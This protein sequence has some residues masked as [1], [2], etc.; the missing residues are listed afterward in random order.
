MV[1][2]MASGNTIP[3]VDC[4]DI[5]MLYSVVDVA[6]LN[7]VLKQILTN[8][9]AAMAGMIESNRPPEPSRSKRPT[10][11]MT[12]FGVTTACVTAVRE[13]L[14]YKGY[15]CLVFHATGTGGRAMEKLVESGY[16]DGVLDITTTEVADEIVGGIM[17]AGSQRIRTIVAKQIPYVVSVGAVDMVNFGA[18]KTVPPQFANRQ[19]H[20][21]NEHVTLMRTTTDENSRIGAWIVE[22]LNESKSPITVVLPVGGVSALDADDEIF[23]NPSANA[24]LFKQFENH[25]NTTEQR[26]LVESAYHVNDPEFADLLV[27]EF[28]GLLPVQI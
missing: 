14:E 12:M 10:V 28:C 20:G 17:P 15:N 23:R 21:H 9:A 19:L 5:F 3:Y 2:T 1:S 24:A 26:Q 6:G 7:Q 27:A 13:R 18:L 25:L 8:A 16:I 11:A 4:S 22:R